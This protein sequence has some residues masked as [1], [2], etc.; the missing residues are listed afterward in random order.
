MAGVRLDLDTRIS[1][2][3][4]IQPQT[5]ASNTTVNGASIDLRTLETGGRVS[6]LA[7][8]G[9]RTDGTYTFVLQDSVDNSAFATIALVSGS[10]AAVSAANTARVGSAEPQPGRPFVRL[11]VTSTSVTTG[12][13]VAGAVLVTPRYI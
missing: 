7:Q 12:A 9:S 6:F 2:T 10:L 4:S 3:A 8:V 1:T 5:I 11:S 13:Q